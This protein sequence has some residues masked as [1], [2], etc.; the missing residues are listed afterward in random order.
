MVRNKIWLIAL[1]L[2]LAAVL[3]FTACGKPAPSPTPTPKTIGEMPNA[4]SKV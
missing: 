4:N 1:T 2:M 3:A